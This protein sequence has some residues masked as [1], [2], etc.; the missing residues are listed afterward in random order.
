MLTTREPYDESVFAKAEQK[1]L[2]AR[3][4]GVDQKLVRLQHLVIE[5]IAGGQAHDGGKI[6]SIERRA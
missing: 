4:P 6:L 3:L 1:N 5:P 2:V